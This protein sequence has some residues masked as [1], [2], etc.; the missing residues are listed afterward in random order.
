[1]NR[2][3]NVLLI[4][5]YIYDVSAYGFWASPL[6]L[7]YMGAIL[8]KAGMRVTLLDCLTEREEKRRADGRAPF[9]KERIDNP[10]ATKGLPKRF[11]RYGMSTEDV[12]GGLRVM[13]K[14]DLVLVT[15]TMTYW[16]P[17]AEE[18]VRLVR[19]AFPT[20]RIVV[21]GIYA[22]LCGEHAMQ[23]MAQADLIV[24][25]GGLDKFYGLV[26]D[27]M[28]DKLSFRPNRDDIADFPYPAFDL[29]RKR[30]YIPL[31]TSV[32]CVYSCTYCATPY[33]R[34]RM[35][36]RAPKSVLGEILHWNE[37]EVSQFALYD[38]AFL[39]GGEEFAKPLLRG[40]T[41]LPTDVA[42]Y[43]PNALNASLVDAELSA[44][45]KGAGFQEVRLGLETA[46]PAVQ[47][48]TGGKI[49]RKGFERAVSRLFE[50][51]FFRSDVQA[52]ILAGLPL[53]K[54]EDVKKS[55]DYAAGLGITVNLA[56]YTPIPHTRMFEQY[57][58]LARYPIAEEPLFQNNALFP[59]A[60]EG[61]TDG[62]MQ[63]LKAYVK[64]K[65]AENDVADSP[66]ALTS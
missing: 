21:G 32:G 40:I 48:A 60:W 29:Y 56:Q 11:K 31:L 61:F 23:R 16:Y 58:H 35:V 55:V 63:H 24:G 28:G 7:L 20:S 13:E 46:D 9:V 45:L 4:N 12:A 64:E 1:L 37:K 42:F 43:N 41:R 18:V 59:F 54:W 3:L 65:N 50:A 57:R 5:P 62:D 8:R 19:E 52:Y 27:L 33:L 10:G 38:D 66:G 30:S 34:D 36:R 17:G 47:R 2:R 51:G 22:A 14:P 44:L 26:E 49:N 25:A 15:C 39:V 53:Q 6:G